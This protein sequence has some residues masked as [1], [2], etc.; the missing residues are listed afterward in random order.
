M[1]RMIIRE[2]KET[3]GRERLPD[4]TGTANGAY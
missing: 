2:Q 4:V 1:G 3:G